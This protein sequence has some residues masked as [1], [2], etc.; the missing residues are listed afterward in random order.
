MDRKVRSAEFETR[1]RKLHKELKE[2]QKGGIKDVEVHDVW[3]MT[4]KYLRC[5]DELKRYAKK[6]AEMKYKRTSQI[7]DDISQFNTIMERYK[8]ELEEASKKTIEVPLKDMLDF[9]ED[10]ISGRSNVMSTLNDAITI[11][12]QMD[13]DCELIEK[14]KDILGPDIIPKHIG[15]IRRI[16][17]SISGFFKKW[18][19]KIISTVVFIVG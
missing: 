11:L 9:V 8:N 12:Q 13:K 16:A 7:D 17:Y 14:R 19:V 3:T 2:G 10:E 5:V 6:F 1:L 15:F 4:N 18:A